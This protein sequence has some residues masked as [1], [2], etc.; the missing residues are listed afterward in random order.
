MRAQ[1]S[2]LVAL[3]GVTGLAGT[4]SAA[5]EW[6]MTDLPLAFD[7][8]LA[9]GPDGQ[10]LAV[11]GGVVYRSLDDGATW[12]PT[13]AL[14]GNA[15]ARHAVYS[16][17]GSLY[18]SDFALGVFRSDDD[19]VGWSGNLVDEGCNGLAVSPLDVVFAGLTYTGNGRVHRSS[20]GGANWSSIPLPGSTQS[21][22]TECFAFGDSGEA[23]AGTIDGFFRSSDHGLTWQRFVSGLG[24]LHVRALAVAP[25]Q[26][27]YAQTVFPSLIDG[28]YRSSDR[29]RTWTRLDVGHPYFA[30]LAATPWGEVL[31][32]ED[33]EVRS[34]TDEGLTWTSTSQGI[35]ANEQ[36]GE[37]LV[38]STGRVLVA[39][40][41]VYRSTQAPLDAGSPNPK[42]I[43]LATPSPNPV[44]GEARIRFSLSHPGRARLS[45]YDL[46]G[47]RVAVLV[48][49]DLPGGAHAARLDAHRLPAGVY[50]CELVAA[51]R[52]ITRRLVVAR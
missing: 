9:Q 1:L 47:R 4:S 19:G 5:L 14:P 33:A 7:Y 12:A 44:T 42:R 30:A 17:T 16:S 11:G 36:L 31:G 32:V 35:A 23:Y 20:D 6:E 15:L 43:A 18:V 45:L 13:G 3:L 37:I 8:A 10:I 34:T 49:G 27:L 26:K 25:N 22:S 41:R 28:V 2:V 39:G 50:V 29:G 52:S 46:S 40:R 24:G 21:F 51:G 48:E 38:A